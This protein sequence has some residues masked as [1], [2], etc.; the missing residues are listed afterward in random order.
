M[1]LQCLGVA[2]P[3]APESDRT[4]SSGVGKGRAVRDK[5][6]GAVWFHVKQ[7]SYFRRI[8]VARAC[9]SARYSYFSRP[10][11]LVWANYGQWHNRHSFDTA[12]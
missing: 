3:K 11:E 8:G 9:C 1:W 7:A 12:C 2:V 10:R 4:S 6:E 5:M